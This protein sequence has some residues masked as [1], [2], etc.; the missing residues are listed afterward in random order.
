MVA[1]GDSFQVVLQVVVVLK[2]GSE[3]WTVVCQLQPL[4]I[5]DDGMMGWRARWWG[6]GLAMAGLDG[7]GLGR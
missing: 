4:A 7:G 2:F 3:R 1:L 5:G 6:G